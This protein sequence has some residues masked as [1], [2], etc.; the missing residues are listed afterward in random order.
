ML[1]H[2]QITELLLINYEILGLEYKYASPPN[3]IYTFTDDKIQCAVTY[4][5]CV[6]IHFNFAYNGAGG[7]LIHF[8][9]HNIY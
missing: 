9:N 4:V 6:Y 2:I 8:S 5:F 1:L 7:N 3:L